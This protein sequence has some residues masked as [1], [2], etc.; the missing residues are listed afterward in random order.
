MAQLLS[1][2]LILLGTTIHYGFCSLMMCSGGCFL[3]RTSFGGRLS[4]TSSDGLGNGGLPSWI[5]PKS[6]IIFQIPRGL[7][8]AT[9]S[10][11]SSLFGSGRG[12]VWIGK[13]T[14]CSR[15]GGESDFCP[16][17][18]SQPC[19]DKTLPCEPEACKADLNVDTS[20]KLTGHARLVTNWSIPNSCEVY[21]QCITLEQLDL[22]GN[23]DTNA[24][25]N[26]P[27]TF[28]MEN[29]D[30]RKTFANLPAY[31]TFKITLRVT[32]LSGVYVTTRTMKT[33]ETRPGAPP[34]NV[35]V[36]KKRK[37]VVFRWEEPPCGTHHGEI[38][39][40]GYKMWSE[41]GSPIVYYTLRSSIAY[42]TNTMRDSRYNFQ[43]CACTQDGD[44]P[45][46]DVIH[47]NV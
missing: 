26:K 4:F 34:L 46:S 31:S 13:R 27:Q 19:L 10:L 30:R 42:F 38:I 37:F 6:K 41:N 43:V 21:Q 1:V 18:E 28:C 2:F 45:Y 35:E 9:R 14:K 23:C 24:V 12:R 16:S 25:V 20:S 15:S 3:S 11:R 7:E 8:T 36:K 22:E 47:V 39:K 44:G 32:S 29:G 40:Y 5:D 17:T 33:K